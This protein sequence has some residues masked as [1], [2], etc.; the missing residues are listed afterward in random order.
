[1]KYNK[2][3]EQI[4][5]FTGWSR[6]HFADL[7]DVSN[8]SFNSWINGHSEPRDKNKTTI[9]NI[10]DKIVVPYVCELEQKADEVEKE[11]LKQ[12]IKNLPDDNIC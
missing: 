9:D 8:N 7:L 4:L 3:L 12:K 6:D 5:A 10:Y 2:K 11:I 1:M